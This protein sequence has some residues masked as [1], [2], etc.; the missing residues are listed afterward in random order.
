MATDI[1]TGR[2]DK[3]QGGFSEEL[4]ATG[5]WQ[6]VA[7]RTDVS[8]LVISARSEEGTMEDGTEFLFSFNADGSAYTPFTYL[9]IPR[10]QDDTMLEFYV[11]SASGNK[12]VLLGL[13]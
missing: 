13:A 5:A 9:I 12:I 6:K 3:K 10:A 7:L 2:Y 11:K 1:A 4:T 8:Q